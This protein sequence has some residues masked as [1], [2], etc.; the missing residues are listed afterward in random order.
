[1]LSLRRDRAW[2][3]SRETGRRHQARTGNGLARAAAVR[4]F[5][6]MLAH[7]RGQ[8]W[9]AS[10]LARS[11]GLS[12]KTVRG[13]L[14]LLTGT[15]M[16][17]QL[18]PWYENLAKRQIKSPKVY[19]RDPGLLHSFLE[20]PDRRALYA[21]PRVGAS[22]EGFVI[23]QLLHIFGPQ[24][25]FFWATHGEAELDLLLLRGTRRYG[26]EIKLSEAPAPTR[27]IHTAIEDLGLDHVWIVYPGE[28][29]IRMDDRITGWPV[30]DVAALADQVLQPAGRRARSTPRSAS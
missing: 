16:V 18:Q 29:V 28:H 24:G 6:T 7:Y 20:L 15:F 26:I 22:F 9:N 14:D 13:Y 3:V 8:I 12:D 27:S 25:T 30:R 11:M 23:E 19:F 4:R 17:R 5:W 1:M 21:H 2:K 10:E